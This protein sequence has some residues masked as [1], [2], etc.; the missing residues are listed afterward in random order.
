MKKQLKYTPEKLSEEELK[1]IKHKMR[2]E[3][4]YD[5]II[6]ILAVLA[7]LVVLMLFIWV[8]S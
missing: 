1:E 7:A 4:I 6:S 2:R 8:I 5:F 3:S